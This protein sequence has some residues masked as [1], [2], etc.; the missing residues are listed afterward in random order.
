MVILRPSYI[1]DARFIKVKVGLLLVTVRLYVLQR[2]AVS[3]KQHKI[4]PKDLLYHRRKILKLSM[5]SR[6]LVTLTVCAKRARSQMAER[7]AGRVGCQLFS[8]S[9]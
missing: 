9:T 5:S 1:Y 6:L 8:I 3:A 7:N 2:D 4:F